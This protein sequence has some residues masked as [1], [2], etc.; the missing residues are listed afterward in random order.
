MHGAEIGGARLE[1]FRAEGGAVRYE[2]EARQS[3]KKVG[4]RVK[5]RASLIAWM[6]NHSSDVVKRVLRIF[7]G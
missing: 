6:A 2:S 7:Y 3:Y 5:S 4:L 1:S